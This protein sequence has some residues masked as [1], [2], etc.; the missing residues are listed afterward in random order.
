MRVDAYRNLQDECISV[1][2]REP[3]TRGQ[4][5]DHAD[6]VVI[7]DAQFVVQPA[8]RRRVLEEERKNVHAFVRGVRA[9]DTPQPSA[10][11]I[12]VTYNPYE[13]DSFV[14]RAD[15]SAV[16]SAELAVVSPSGVL[17][18]NVE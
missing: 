5:I 15:E 4:V 6:E 9:D 3:E 8:G 17:A 1:K 18:F 7:K 11:G 2:S 14:Q 12:E 10:G 13:Y 16:S